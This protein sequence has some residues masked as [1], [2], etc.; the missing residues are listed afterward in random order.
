M[1]HGTR[2]L[3]NFIFCNKETTITETEYTNMAH[4]GINSGFCELI[5]FDN[6]NIRKTCIK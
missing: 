1:H 5:T 6:K 4:I 2:Y 3:V